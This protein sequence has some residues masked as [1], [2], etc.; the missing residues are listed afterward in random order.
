MAVRQLQVSG[1]FS[2]YSKRRHLAAKLKI[3]VSF[4]LGLDNHWKEFCWHTDLDAGSTYA[5]GWEE[6]YDPNS[7]STVHSHINY[8]L[9]YQS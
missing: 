8:T 4:I 3:A 2:T 9:T 1:S 5:V 6:I 7:D